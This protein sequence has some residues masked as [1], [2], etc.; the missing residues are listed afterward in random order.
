M[1]VFRAHE[2]FLLIV[3][4]E[5]YLLFCGRLNRVEEEVLE[6]QAAISPAKSVLQLLLEILFKFAPRP[7]IRKVFSCL[8]VDCQM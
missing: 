8:S 2:T 7:F 4:Y 3:L 6:K 5:K 1:Y